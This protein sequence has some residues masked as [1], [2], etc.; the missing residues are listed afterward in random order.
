M[1]LL[2]KLNLKC[3][4]IDTRRST[5]IKHAETWNDA[6]KVIFYIPIKFVIFGTI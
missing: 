1:S 2:M 4:L 3:S 5:Y 6:V